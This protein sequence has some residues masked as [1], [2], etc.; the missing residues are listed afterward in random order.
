MRIGLTAVAVAVGLLATA[1]VG[2]QG[3]R[4]PDIT[5]DWPEEATY[6]SAESLDRVTEELQ[7]RA[8]ASARHVAAKPLLMTRTHVVLAIH[9]DATGTVEQHGGMTDYWIVIAGEN[10]LVLGGEVVDREEIGPGEF[11]G[12]LI[13]GGREIPVKAGDQIDIPPNMPHHV[14]VDEGKSI[15]YLNIKV[16][17]GMYPWSFLR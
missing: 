15:T 1:A 13:K 17:I 6:W 7:Q 8:A 3:F 10:T 11:R 4:P 12:S 16:N 5:V 9:R 14:I 2:A